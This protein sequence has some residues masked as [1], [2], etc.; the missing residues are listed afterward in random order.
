MSVAFSYTDQKSKRG[1]SNLLGNSIYFLVVFKTNIFFVLLKEELSNNS[2]SQ[3]LELFRFEI[4]LLMFH[5]LL[6]RTNLSSGQRKES[7]GVISILV[8]Q[9]K[10][11]LKNLENC[12]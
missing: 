12:A 1:K 2:T 3:N 11:D 8:P 9:S 7:W 5:M 10:K 6:M 4:L